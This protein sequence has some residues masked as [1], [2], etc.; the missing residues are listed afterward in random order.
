MPVRA[1]LREKEVL[2]KE[3]HHRVKNN[4]QIISSLLSLQDGTITDPHVLAM[5]ED[6]QH[7][8]TS[9]A[10]IHQS[11]YQTDNPARVDF[12]AYLR[13]LTADLWRAYAVDP[14]H[15][16]L[17]MTADDLSLS[18]D[19][20]VPC[21]LLVNELLTNSLKHAFPD[22]RS[23]TIQ[24][25][26]RREAQGQIILKVSDTG[27]G[28]PDGVDLQTAG[29]FGLQLVKIVCMQLQAAIDLQRQPGTTVTITFAEATAQAHG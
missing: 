16:T 13:S 20:A 9:M 6:C 11:L 8:I 7:R 22:G 10:L 24:V 14:T 12:A 15:I 21:G 28:L 5:F 3:M 4:L 26:L 19:V 23:G 18:L 2:L 27:I 29:S 17:T 25:D 1:S